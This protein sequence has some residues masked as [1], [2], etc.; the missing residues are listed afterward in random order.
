GERQDA[1]P[2]KPSPPDDTRLA[3]PGDSVPLEITLADDIGVVWAEV[4]YRVNDGPSQWQPIALA[5][6]GSREASGQALFK[7][8]D[9][10]LKEGDTLLYRIR[11]ADNRSVPE[12]GLE[13][14]TIYYPPGQSWLT[15]KITGQAT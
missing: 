3:L 9:K 10:G 14:H 4:E 7:R 15:L 11:A 2:T 13:P 8:T 5:G 1:K 6:A 12:A